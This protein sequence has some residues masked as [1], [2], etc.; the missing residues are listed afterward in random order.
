MKI[1]AKLL[2]IVALSVA[3]V[4]C[5]VT[6]PVRDSGTH[7]MR[8]AIQPYVDKGWCPGAISVLYKDGVQETACIGYADVAAKRMFEQLS[9]LD[10][11]DG[12]R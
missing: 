4:G 7:Y 12:A 5:S 2:G 1:K 10:R 11:G 8:D 3:L 6:S 9:D